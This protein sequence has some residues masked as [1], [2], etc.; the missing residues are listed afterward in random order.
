MN[1]SMNGP[2]EKVGGRT[3]IGIYRWLKII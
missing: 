2:E 3:L 1:I